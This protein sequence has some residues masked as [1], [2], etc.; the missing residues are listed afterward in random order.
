[1]LPQRNIRFPDNTAI[2]LDDVS[3]L[4]EMSL[5]VAQGC[6]INRNRS[7]RLFVEGRAALQRNSPRL[8]QE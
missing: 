7:S 2:A 3:F 1:M 8:C 4:S 6:L 5:K